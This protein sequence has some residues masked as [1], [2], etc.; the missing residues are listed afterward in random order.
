MDTPRF[1]NVHVMA[2]P[3]G[4]VC[5]LA[6]AYCYYLEKQA[7]YPAT[8]S[9]RI[10]DETIELF[11]RKYIGAQESPQVDFAWQGGEPLLMGLPFF[12]RVVEL[13]KRHAGGKRIANALQTNGLLVDDAWC[14]FFTQNE[15]LVG[16]SL[17]GPRELHDRYRRDS[18]GGPSF[19]KVVRALE[20]LL[21]H[22]VEVNSLTVISAANEHH[23][24][25]VYDFLKRQGIRFMQF[26]PLVER[27]ADSSA[28]KLGLSLAQP[29]GPGDFVRRP[30]VAP[31]AVNPAAYGSFLTTIFDHWVRIDVGS[32]F[33]QLFDVA[34]GAWMGLGAALCIFS[35]RC[36][37]AL[38]LEH[39]G[40]L[41]SCD[42]F[43][44]PDFRV[45][46]IHDNLPLRDLVHSPLQVK[47]GNDKRDTL[48]R[49]CIECP[50][51]FACNG[52]CPKHRFVT[53]PEGD[54]NLS[55]LCPGYKRFFTHIGPQM[56]VM[57]QLVSA[58]RPAAEIMGMLDQERAEA[59]W[60]SVKR[61]DPCPCGSGKKFKLCCGRND[62]P[63]P[64]RKESTP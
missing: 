59:Q 22:G 44:Y 33:V 47:F 16:L 19:D 58:G 41:Y 50:V 28:R 34:L 48:P 51:R 60:Q 38:I 42:H 24:L 39:N 2:K 45:G 12:E 53:S 40:D 8:S 37:T 35:E 11:V 36:G 29:A 61:N 56:Q 21:A 26:I 57:A 25:D 64:A 52:D 9:F 10:T 49:C 18:R 27:V 54:P 4:P 13:Q 17:D 31:W 5:N 43:T 3:I 7:L 15:F 62:R 1:Q 63:A 55:Y 14:R 46:S 30:Q 32:V 23:P 6:C 20:L